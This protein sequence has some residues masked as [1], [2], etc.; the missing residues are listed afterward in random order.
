M[1]PAVLI[2]FTVSLV[3]VIFASPG[4]A[5]GR[6][7]FAVSPSLDNQERPDVHGERIVWQQLVEYAGVWAWD[8]YLTDLGA[9]SITAT[10]ITP[11]E[12]DQQSPSIYGDSVVWEDNTEADWDFFLTDITDPADPILYDVGYLDGNQRNPAISGNIVVWQDDA[13]G[14]FDIA[15]AD[16]TALISGAGQDTPE[17]AYFWVTALETIRQEQPA[18]YRNTVLWQDDYDGNDNWEIV[19]ADIWRQNNPIENVVSYTESDKEFCSVWGDIVVWQEDFGGDWDIWAAD[20]SRPDLPVEFPV[21]QA[22]LSQ[23]NPDVGDNLVVWQDYRNGEDWD[24]YGYNLTTGQEFQITDN[25]ADQINPAVSGNLV[26]WE[27]YRDGY[28][29]IY[30]VEL[31][32]PE[33]ARCDVKPAGDTNGDC[34]TDL[35][36]LATIAQTWLNCGLDDQ[37]ACAW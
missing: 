21:S 14:A 29:N 16:V 24:I 13:W 25:G 15:G 2:R 33:V 20:I 27:D 19:S 32:G 22:A 4:L 30:A 12:Y 9:E 37:T 11:Y 7:E 3:V 10:D 6:Q 28:P 35:G 36:D 23:T 18:I 34:R 17:A 26:V 8:I 1:K 5:G 31:T